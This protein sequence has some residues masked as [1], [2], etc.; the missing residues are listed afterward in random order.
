MERLSKEKDQAQ[1]DYD[2]ATIQN[3]DELAVIGRRTLM[4]AIKEMSSLDEDPEQGLTLLGA[5]A[6]EDV[7][8][9]EVAQVVS[10]FKRA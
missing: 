8:Q 2:N 1:Q 3:M 6:L 10:D 5:T 4:F 7:L 9:D